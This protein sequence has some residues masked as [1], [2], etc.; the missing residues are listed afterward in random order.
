VTNIIPPGTIVAV[1]DQIRALAK[2][3]EDSQTDPQG[4][5]VQAKGWLTDLHGVNFAGVPLNFQLAASRK[6]GEEEY[7]GNGQT[8]VG[9]L[10][11]WCL[12]DTYW[13]TAKS[14]KKQVDIQL[15]EFYT[16]L[17]PAKGPGT[18]TGA[19]VYDMVSTLVSTL[20]KV[21]DDYDKGSDKVA[22]DLSKLASQLSSA[23]AVSNPS[24][25]KS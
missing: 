20:R 12:D 17:T 6:D 15:K 22:A 14:L 1:P 16:R 11:G 4:L 23:S 9:I 8:T 5:F 7:V 24:G 19:S 2:W 13:A 21:A 3:L 18:M 25:S 10:P